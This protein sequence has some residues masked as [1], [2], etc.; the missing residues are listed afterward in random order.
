MRGDGVRSRV[1]RAAPLTL[2]I[3]YAL[4]VLALH[5]SI[6]QLALLAV[7]AAI[8]VCAI[9]A[10]PASILL[11]KHMVRRGRAGDTTPLPRVV[12]ELAH[13]RWRE[14]RCR[15]IWQPLVMLALVMS[16]FNIF[17][18]FILP[19]AGFWA[20]PTIA[21]ADRALFFGID[22]WR[23]THAL[24]PSP[25]A[26]QFLDLGYHAWFAPMTL[27]IALCACARP[28]SVLAMRYQL[29]FCLLW[30]VQG[31]LLAYLLPAAGPTFYATFQQE[32]GRF[33]DLTR[34]LVA[35]DAYLR[36]VGA[37]GLSALTY[38]NYLLH[39]FGTDTIALGGGISAMPSLHNAHAVLFAC[40]ARHLS[41]RLGRI[42]IG[43]AFI[44]W[45]G[46]IHLS[47]HYA[48]DGIVALVATMVIWKAT[49][50][51][52]HIGAGGRTAGRALPQFA[53]VGR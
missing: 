16:A 19:G 5:G 52:A 23:I 4:F 6:G 49:G 13:R 47:W 39:M 20:G 28:G 44:I 12:A 10:F 53:G 45:I 50:V 48:L 7:G 18:Q 51:I 1:V 35:Q 29:A 33:A 14:D 32:T 41:P 36:S 34:E 3:G 46:S 17:K 25:W 9:A 22:P 15:S 26:T 42:A 40:A 24:F 38:Q 30:I 27:G 31:S 37:P 11:M 8:G 43:Y 21:A 2:A